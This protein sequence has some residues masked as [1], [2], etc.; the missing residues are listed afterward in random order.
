MLIVFELMSLEAALELVLELLLYGVVDCLFGTLV[1]SIGAPF[2]VGSGSAGGAAANAP[3]AISASASPPAS[4]VGERV[5]KIFMGLLLLK[6]RIK[7]HQPWISKQ[8]FD[9]AGM[10]VHSRGKSTRLLSAIRGR[11]T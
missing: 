8:R 1:S 2:D 7:A 10:R 6:R 4:N 3:A 11:G 9:A 5:F